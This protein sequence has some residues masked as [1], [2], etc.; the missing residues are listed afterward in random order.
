MSS[1]ISYY[2]TSLG[3][4]GK[5]VDSLTVTGLAD[6]EDLY[7]KTLNFATAGNFTAAVSGSSSVPEPTS[8]M[9]VLV[10]LCGLALKRKR[11]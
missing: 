11:A 7:A 4:N 6:D 2:D 1:N 3:T 5:V 9:L 10:G 8:A